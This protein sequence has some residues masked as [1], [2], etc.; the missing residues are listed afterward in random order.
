GLARR[1]INAVQSEIAVLQ[2]AV[3]DHFPILLVYG[4]Q[5]VAFLV[6]KVAQLAALKIFPV[7]D[8][9]RQP[10]VVAFEAPAPVDGLTPDLACGRSGLLRR[11]AALPG[12]DEVIERLQ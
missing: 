2:F 9:H 4:S 7:L 8:F 12:A 11:A 10:G 1:R 5:L 3:E 6:D